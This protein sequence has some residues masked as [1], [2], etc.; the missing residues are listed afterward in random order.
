MLKVDDICPTYVDQDLYDAI[1]FIVD[2]YNQVS[3]AYEAKVYFRQS[4]ASLKKNFSS[5]EKVV[6]DNILVD[7]EKVAV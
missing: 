1:E 3:D 7:F 6:I 4:L 5:D 2:N